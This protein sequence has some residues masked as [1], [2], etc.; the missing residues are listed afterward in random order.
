M[1]G[2]AGANTRFWGATT[3]L[4]APALVPFEFL[5]E[6]PPNG[7][8]PLFP[9]Q[10]EFM[11]VICLFF[12][13]VLSGTPNTVLTTGKGMYYLGT[14]SQIDVTREDNKANHDSK[15]FRPKIFTGSGDHSTLM[16]RT[17]RLW[18]HPFRTQPPYKEFYLHMYAD[19]YIYIHLMYVIY[20]NV[21]IFIHIYIHL[22]I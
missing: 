18:S 12:D 14:P 11:K 8:Q 1:Y 7:W 15:H 5:R 10:S 16:N 22:N 6:G 19:G 20:I 21:H 9:S 4:L 13:Y 2:F 3:Y 17:A